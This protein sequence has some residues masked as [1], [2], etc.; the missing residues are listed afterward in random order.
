MSTDEKNYPTPCVHGELEKISD[1]VYVVHGS[2]K[3]APG[4]RISL[5]MTIL[6]R[7]AD[8]TVVN[9]MRVNSE[10]EDA[11]KE[12]GTVKNVVR[13]CSNHGACDEYYIDSFK[14]TYYDIKESVTA[15]GATKVPATENYLEDGKA[16]PGIPDSKVIFV[17]GLKMPD[18]MILHPDKGGI[19][20]VGDFIQNGRKA[21]H[22]TF[23]YDYVLGKLLGFNTGVL[24][25][26]PP[27]LKLYGKGEDVYGPNVPS[28]LEME[29]DTIIP[30]HGPKMVG[31]AKDDLKKGWAKMKKGD[32]WQC[33]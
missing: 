22:T 20:I 25:T 31:G 6:K 27:F 5:T 23:M 13:I 30:S 2:F 18:A 33:P 9:S 32:N 26:P 16:V 15:E 7:D 29:F 21:P 4:L 12:L 28:L 19:L 8:L 1:N 3:M 11:I 10:V 14:A 24:T 17:K